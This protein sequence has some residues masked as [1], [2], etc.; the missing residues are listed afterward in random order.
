[1]NARERLVMR[2]ERRTSEL[3]SGLEIPDAPRRNSP[4]HGHGL[5]RM[6]ARGC[7]LRQVRSLH[8]AASQVAALCGESGRCTLRRVRSLHFAAS[9][10]AALCG[11]SGRCTLRRVRSLH[12][13]ASQVAALCGE[14]GR[15]TLRRLW[16]RPTSL[17]VVRRRR[18][19]GASGR[20]EYPVG[21]TVLPRTQR[22][23]GRCHFGSMPL[24][25][26]RFA[27]DIEG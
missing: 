6:I 20:P 9:Q 10:V 13:A 3:R 17:K 15:C 25:G 22:S 11:E 18:G 7:T 4:L 8:F 19:V 27:L 1:M 12:F 23:L 24:A 2:R 16:S 26:R 14:S 5:P 21:D